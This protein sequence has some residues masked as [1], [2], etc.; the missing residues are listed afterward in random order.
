[1]TSTSKPS[2]LQQSAIERSAAKVQAQ[3]SSLQATI[4][5]R[6]ILIAAASKLCIHH[7]SKVEDI[8]A[9]GSDHARRTHGQRDHVARHAVEQEVAVDVGAVPQLQVL[10]QRHLLLALHHRACVH[11]TR[12]RAMPWRWLSWADHH[13]RQGDKLVE[14]CFMCARHTVLVLVPHGTPVEPIS[15]PW[16]RAAAASCAFASVAGLSSSSASHQKL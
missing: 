13:S 16:A 2:G 6:A 3:G 9:F 5:Q 10:R 4:L 15:S 12:H 11:D 7:A 14:V 1:M 8:G